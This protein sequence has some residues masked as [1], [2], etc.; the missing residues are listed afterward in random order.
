MD[1]VRAISAEFAF[2]RKKL[3]LG[4]KV[5]TIK[6]DGTVTPDR[7]IQNLVA[8]RG[9]VA[10][11]GDRVQITALE[12]KEK[13]II[14][15][16]NGGPKKK[17]PWYK[18]V[19][20]GVNGRSTPIDPRVDPES[21]G[22]SIVVEYDKHVPDMTAAQLRQRLEPIFDF[23]VKSAAQAYTETLP[24]NVQ[25]AIKDH[26]V[27]VGMTKEM[28]TYSKGRPPQRL[29]EKDEHQNDYE[30]WIFGQPPEDV[31]FVR[32]VGDEVVQLK[33]MKVDGEKVVRTEKEVIMPAPG[34][35]AE[36]ASDPQPTGQTPGPSGQAP[37]LRRPGEAAPGLQGEVTS[38]KPAKKPS[39]PRTPDS[40]PEDS[41]RLLLPSPVPTH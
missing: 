16:I 7:E 9:Q 41:P 40:P 22:L 32:F 31:E 20:F 11:A 28:V 18:R 12:F 13:S 4:P 29:R 1:L 26:R 8:Q 25:D 21:R 24:K 2:T 19:E 30:E 23:S 10:R 6:P 14:I 17:V 38:S 36:V 35:A 37:T 27:L 33:I 3:P 5:I 34:A 15:E 39:A